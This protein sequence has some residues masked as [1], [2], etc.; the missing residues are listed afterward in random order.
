MIDTY[1]TYGWA[2]WHQDRARLL[3]LLGM[4]SDLVMNERSSITEGWLV[5]WL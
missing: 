1:E 3:F 2:L 4:G 5:A